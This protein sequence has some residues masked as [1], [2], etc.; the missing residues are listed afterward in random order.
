MTLH[1]LGWRKP[2]PDGNQRLGVGDAIGRVLVEHRSGYVVA[3]DAGE[4]SAGVAGRLRFDATSGY[5]PGLPVVGD[6]VV[7]HTG[8]SP[9]EGRATIQS[10]LPR[11]GV[12]VRKEGGR[13]S[14]AQVV[15][16]NVDIAFLV[17]AVV[18]DLNS[19]RLERYV[20][21][22]REGGIAPVIVLTKA[23]LAENELALDSAREQVAASAPGIP[24]HAVCALDGRGVAELE[25]YFDDR[26]TVVL[27]GSSGVGKSTLINRLLGCDAQQV[28]GVREDG[29]GRHTTTH[30]SLFPRPGGGVVIDT[31]G[32]RELALYG[33]DDGVASAFPEIEELAAHCRFRDCSHRTEPGCAVR[34]AVSDGALAAERLAGYEKLQAE[35]RHLEAK[36]NPRVQLERKRQIKAIHRAAYRRLDEKNWR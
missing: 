29:K 14:A 13:T 22:A 25:A 20:A 30:R 4:M 19:R 31:P 15:A 11:R 16:A 3:T 10:I 35:I 27:L 17:T 1:D 18:G 8:L 23:D 6:W 34:A 12:F 2:P 26:P 36:A 9:G 32:M 33:S 7:V 24:T 5:A 28:Q 21:L